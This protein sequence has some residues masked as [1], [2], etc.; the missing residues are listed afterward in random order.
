M[1]PQSCSHTFNV[2]EAMENNRTTAYHGLLP[3]KYIRPRSR[4]RSSQFILKH[5]SLSFYPKSHDYILSPPIKHNSCLS[6]SHGWLK[7]VVCMEEQPLPPAST[8]RYRDDMLY[9]NMR[10]QLTL[11]PWQ[12][13]QRITVLQ[14]IT[15]PTTLAAS[16]MCFGFALYSSGEMLW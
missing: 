3:W 13:S 6:Y 4:E 12:P 10:T 15:P 2:L 8:C 7:M 5:S 9:W 14:H 16:E 11:L 1:P